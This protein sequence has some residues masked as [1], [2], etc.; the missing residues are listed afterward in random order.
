MNTKN[1]KN[2]NFIEQISSIFNLTEISEKEF[3]LLINSSVKD[4]NQKEITFE[5]KILKP[6][7]A[8]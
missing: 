8:S 2:E 3:K 1:L 6:K 5:N 7:K 4:I